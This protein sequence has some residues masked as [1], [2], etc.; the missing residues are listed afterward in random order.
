MKIKMNMNN[1]FNEAGYL[2]IPK[3]WNEPT[4]DEL[5]AT[6]DRLKGWLIAATLA[7]AL[8]WVSFLMLVL[9]F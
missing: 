7:A 9:W 2:L 6:V 4:K 8:G 3:F 1:R 5:R